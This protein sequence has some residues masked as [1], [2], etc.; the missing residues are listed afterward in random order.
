MKRFSG[1]ITPSLL[2]A[3]TFAVSAGDAVETPTWRAVLPERNRG[4]HAS[5]QEVNRGRPRNWARAVLAF[6]RKQ[7]AGRDRQEHLQ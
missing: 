3:L 7:P 1:V 6:V 5:G 4:E 2:L